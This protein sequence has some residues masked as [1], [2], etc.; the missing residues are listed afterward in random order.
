MG[1]AEPLLHDRAGS[2]ISLPK[3]GWSEGM[4]L[5]SRAGEAHM[6]CTL[7]SFKGWHS[8]SYSIHFLGAVEEVLTVCVRFLPR[9]S[10]MATGPFYTI[11]AKSTSTGREGRKLAPPLLWGCQELV[12]L[13]AQVRTAFRCCLY[14]HC[15][16]NG[17]YYRHPGYLTTFWPPTPA[18]PTAAALPPHLSTGP[19]LRQNPS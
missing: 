9:S 18:T 13:P 6:M 5:H 11:R 3:W 15:C 16:C 4:A 12:G 7:H 1:E 14:L 8:C 17:P 19:F 10:P 2:C